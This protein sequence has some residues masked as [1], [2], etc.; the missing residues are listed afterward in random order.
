MDEKTK[1]DKLSEIFESDLLGLLAVDDPKATPVSTQD[2][3][4]IDSFQEIS[5]FYETNQRCP[6]LGDD[7]GEYRLASRLAAIKKDP[8]KVKTL[9]PYDYYNLL[10]R[11]ETK[12]V[13]V[14]EL[15]SDD[16][17]GLLDGDDEANSIYTL[18][19][20][21][22][23]ERLRPDYIAHRKVCKD[24]DLYEEAFQRIHDDLEHGRRRLVEFKEGDLHEGCYYVLR[25]VVLYLEQNLAVKQKIEYKSGAKVRREGRTRCI[26]D[27]GT[28]SSMLYRSLGKAL[29][30][31]GFCISDLIEK[32]E[33]S[34]SIDSTDVQNGYIY[35]LRSLSRAP[36][37][38]SIR[39]LYKIGYCS[40]D[41][42]TRIKNAVHEPTYLM[43]DVEV[44]LT[45]RCYNLDVPYL[46]ASIHSFFSNVN[47]YFGVRD[48]EGIMHYPKEWFTVPLNIIEEA[49]P[50]IVDKKIDSYRYD[51]NLQMIIQKGSSE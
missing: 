6:E 42:T 7:I 33:S 12:S 16:P 43:N 10:E 1:K 9:L 45:V 20:V 35:V 13:S 4:L 30:L 31:D 18:S 17:L 3:R 34:V 41:V 36:Q 24:F 25:G 50:L 28:E 15:I 51:K 37:I 44:V 46:E 40:G 49:I 47:V 38:R 27:N 11:E 14:E 21:K 29:K 39:N 48:D 26:F 32:N 2:S 19:H 5:D 22:P 8:K 23:S